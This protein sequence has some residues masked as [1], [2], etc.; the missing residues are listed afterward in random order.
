MNLRLN[1]SVLY[2]AEEESCDKSLTQMVPPI[3]AITF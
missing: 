1:T 2:S 3:T